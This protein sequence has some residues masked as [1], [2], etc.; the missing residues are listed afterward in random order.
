MT[1]VLILIILCRKIAISL[2]PNLYL[3]LITVGK[4]EFVRCGFEEKN[5]ETYNRSAWEQ[6]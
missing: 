6:V 2:E 5:Y 4:F 1:Q 3:D